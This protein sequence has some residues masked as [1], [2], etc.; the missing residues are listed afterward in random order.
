[1][2][3]SAA[4]VL[5]KLEPMINGTVILMF[6]PA[7]EGGAGGKRMVE[8]GVLQQCSFVVEA[9]LPSSPKKKQWGVERAFG[10]HLWPTLPSNVIASRPGTL[11]AACDRFIILI[12]GTGSH[13]AMPHQGADPI[14]AGSAMVAAF[15][16]I[17]SRRTSPLEAAV[18]SITKFDSAGTAFNVIPEAVELYGTVRSLTEVGLRTL[19]N[20]VEK[21][22]SSVSASY[23]CN[24]TVIWSVD[25]YPPTV[26]DAD[27]F[28]F[29]K[30]VGDKASFGGEVV[31]IVPTMGAE[32]F[33]F[34]GREVPSVF[35]FLG[36][37]GDE[38]GESG[39]IKKGSE[40]GFGLHHP[41]FKMD[42]SVL[43]TGVELHVRLALESIEDLWRERATHGGR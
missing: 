8:E 24:A 28:D 15:Q 36:Q 11:M 22:T 27:L 9:P 7:E 32:D 13:A 35:F 12:H 3:L 4:A 14:V 41:H 16:T 30:S 26:N 1:M 43:V 38:K 10:L 19:M 33:G 18:V 25:Y 5:K 29:A 23:N 40:T 17:V 31:E 42:E 2:L 39:E 20:E 37:G 21:V 34:L 6:Q